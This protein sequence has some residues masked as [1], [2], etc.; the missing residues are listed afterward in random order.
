MMLS[1]MASTCSSTQCNK[2]LSESLIA[3]VTKGPWAGWFKQQHLFLTVL[4]AKSMIKAPI[5]PGV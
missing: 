4:E 1:P 2:T 5:D 3:A